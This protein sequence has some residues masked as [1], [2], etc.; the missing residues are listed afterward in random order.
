MYR[1]VNITLAEETLKLIDRAAAKGDR[2]R[3]ISEAVRYYVQAQGRKRLRELL[4][5]GALKR[6]E[7][8]LALVEEWFPM[9]EEVWRRRRR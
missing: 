7:R 2:S 6:A 8:D 4:K 3:F 9:E 5:E 1:R